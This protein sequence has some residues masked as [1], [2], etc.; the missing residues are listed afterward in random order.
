M[1]A[2]AFTYHA[3]RTV[4]EAV[5]LLGR[6][7]NARVL[8]G[9]QSLMPMLNLRIA[10]P[11]HL[12]DLGRVA[13]LTGIEDRGSVI[14]IGAMTTQRTLER[15]ELVRNNI[16]LLAHAV[17]HVGHQQTRNRGTLG[18]SICHLDPSA[19]LPVAAAALDAVLTVEGSTGRRRIPFTEFPAG[20]L[21]NA[22]APDEILVEIEFRKAGPRGGA[23]FME[24]NRRPA[25]FA[26]VSV[27]IEVCLGSRD[28]IER[29]AIAVGGIAF[30][31]V[32]MTEIEAALAGRPFAAA[33]LA[34][35]LGSFDSI[36]VDGDDIYPSDF[37]REL[38]GVLTERAL[39]AAIQSA[40]GHA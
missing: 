17:D 15:S 29:V 19:E 6:L 23:A 22:L 28:H 39:K 36:D 20:Y 12:I 33:T 40:G 31:P 9:G 11:D 13:G 7:D 30:A 32:R 8:A 3:P 38:C 4:A 37:R 14:A 26:V 16:P 25:D 21:T 10:A 18:G 2:P 5:S 34:E 35:A 1:K 27:A 24:F